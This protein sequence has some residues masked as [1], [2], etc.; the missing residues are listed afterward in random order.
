MLVMIPGTR[1]AGDVRR[2][3]RIVLQSPITGAADP[4]QELKIRGRAAVVDDDVQREATADRIEAVSGWRPGPS[5]LFLALP[6]RERGAD[7]MGAGRDVADSLGPGQW[8]AAAGAA[9]PRPLGR[10][11][12]I[13]RSVKLCPITQ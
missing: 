2:D 10:P 9:A 7:G 8:V 12:H 4:G 6:D 5:W 1:K 11:L 13:G 3:S